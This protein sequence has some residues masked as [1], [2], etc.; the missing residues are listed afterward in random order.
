MH[1][2]PRRFVA[3]AA[4][5]VMAISSAAQGQPGPGWALAGRLQP[6]ALHSPYALQA[7]P[8]GRTF[9]YAAADAD[10][11]HLHLLE[12]ETGR[13]RRLTR[14]AGTRRDP[15]WSHDGR[16]IAYWGNI[17]LPTGDTAQGI[18]VVDARTGRE[19][20]AYASPD[21]MFSIHPGWMAD[22]RIVFQRELLIGMSADVTNTPAAA[23]PLGE[24]VV[25]MWMV[26]ADGRDP[27]PYRR[28]GMGTVAFSRDG[29]RAAWRGRG[30][31]GGA[32]GGA[33]WVGTPP[34]L[35]DARCLA[36]VP[37][38]PEHMAWAADGTALYV[39][40]DSGAG[41]SPRIYR[42][43]VTGEAPV[44]AG[45][46][47]GRITGLSVTAAG[48]VAVSIFR[49]DSWIGTVRADG[50]GEPRLLPRPTGEH[51]FWPEWHPDGRR[52][53]AVVTP[54]SDESPWW[55][56]A[57][58]AAP[59]GAGPNAWRRPAAADAWRTRRYPNANVVAGTWS[60][61]G[62]RL[63]TLAHV[64]GSWM[65]GMAA[66]PR[67]DSSRVQIAWAEADGRAPPPA[68][69][70]DGAALVVAPGDVP[71]WDAHGKHPRGQ[72]IVVDAPGLGETYPRL[73]PRTRL[74]LEGFEGEPTLPRVS[75]DGRWIAF[76]RRPDD[77]RSGVYVVP[78]G[79]GAVR[80]L[81]SFATPDLLSGPEWSRDGAH[82]YF[83]APD[84]AGT[85]RIHRVARGGGVPR[86]L[87]RGPR[88]ALHPRLSPDGRTLAVT[89][90]D[91]PTEVWIL[92][93]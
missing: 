14:G 41:G 88:H 91:A 73:E 67:P 81:A 42:A 36:S 78:I 32:E 47:E 33:A 10:G 7:S 69:T 74:A 21:F 92:A 89:L 17:P 13:T 75:P 87:T 53:A 45:A 23:A 82:V 49:P 8:D 26:Q 15:R 16:F 70:P 85:Q 62:E 55:G 11:V 12:R 4:A 29:T 52:L 71:A 86:V 18:G 6:A 58:V 65:L 37:V 50:G 54:W 56:A 93:P 59:A 22:G 31:G 72:L 38:P 24:G 83:S 34:A 48:E 61:D 90:W 2:I 20:A 63:A 60:P 43:P 3:L 35:D 66:A 5:A 25:E 76:A 68:W 64:G 84:A 30:C 51:A 27:R 40:G 44:R 19:W 1:L 39:A 77:G 28:S 79:G 9:V 46:A 57:L 80:T